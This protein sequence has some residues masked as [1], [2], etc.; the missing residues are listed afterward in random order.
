MSAPRE[1]PRKLGMTSQM[2]FQTEP[3]PED[4]ARYSIIFILDGA[5]YD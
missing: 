4:A 3:V 2:G 1:I 5:G